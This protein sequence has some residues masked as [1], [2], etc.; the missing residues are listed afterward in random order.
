MNINVGKFRYLAE[1]ESEYAQKT[2]DH[3]AYA[4]TVASRLNGVSDFEVY[5]NG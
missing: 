5:R 4:W 1:D 3:F 2:H